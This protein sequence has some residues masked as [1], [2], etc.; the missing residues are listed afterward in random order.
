MTKEELSPPNK[1]EI[2]II[3]ADDEEL[4]KKANMRI[5]NKIAKEKNINLNIIESRDGVE[6]LNLIYEYYYKTNKKI[7]AVISDESMQCINGIKCAEIIKF[8]FPEVNS[9]PYYLVTSYENISI[10]SKII[11]KV[12]SKPLRS[13]D[14]EFIL[15]I[16]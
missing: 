3:L 13:A 8:Y 9:I 5:L 4:P 1:I 15:C 6:T 12:F 11:N 7:S 10:D 14:A 16:T 2:N